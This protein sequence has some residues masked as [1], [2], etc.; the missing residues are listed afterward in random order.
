MELRDDV[1]AVPQSSSGQG[2][3]RETKTPEAQVAKCNEAISIGIY[4]Y[5]GGV[6][7]IFPHDPDYD[8]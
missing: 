5:E 6:T 2:A 3:C 8:C 4:P 7:E 1:T